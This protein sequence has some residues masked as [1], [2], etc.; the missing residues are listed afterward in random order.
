[1]IE[2]LEIIADDKNL[3]GEA[4]TWDAAHNRVLWVDA[5]SNL[6]FQL[7]LSSNTKSIINRDLMVIGIVLDRSGSLMFCG[8][9]GL[10]LW[11]NT[12]GYR[13]LLVEHAGEE[14]SFN[15][16]T[17]DSHGRIYAGTKHWTEKMEKFG[18]LYRIDP[19]GSVHVMDDGIELSNGLGFSPDNRT[20]YYAD[21]T[22]RK[23]YA[24]G[25]DPATGAL[26]HKRTFVQIPSDEGLP[27]GLTV[28]ADGFVWSAQWYGGQVVRYDLDG[29]V[30]RRIKLPVAQV[31]SVTFGG[32][33][34]QDLYITSA[35]DYWP[36]LY[37]PTGFN[38]HGPIG[39]PLYRIHLEDV[40]GK[41]ECTSNLASASRFTS[42]R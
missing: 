4:P 31:S 25:A 8:T 9:T 26:S 13:T 14:L 21:S 7:D 23:I 30:E 37:L 19:D 2:K 24:Y 11:S 42:Q 39:G 12:G 16:M 20:L 1:M 10:H 3:C 6:V 41:P 17:A 33:N 40:R 28:D 32:G 27:D 5:G 34:L 36:S 29:K 18:R 15:D 22:A 35:A 38:A